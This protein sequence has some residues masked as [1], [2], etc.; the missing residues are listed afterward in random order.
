LT[1]TYGSADKAINLLDS[2]QFRS[3][4]GDLVLDAS[5]GICP[6]ERADS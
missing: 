1:A 2:D 6:R 4:I 3:R 5:I